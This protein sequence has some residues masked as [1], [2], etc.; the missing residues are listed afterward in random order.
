VVQSLHMQVEEGHFSIYHFNGFKQAI[1]K[2]QTPVIGGDNWRIGRN[3]L[4]IVK[5]PVVH[6]VKFWKE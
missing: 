6:E 2:T 3:D 5:Q 4:F 1:A